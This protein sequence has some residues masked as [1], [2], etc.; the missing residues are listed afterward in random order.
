VGRHALGPACAW[1][2]KPK[3]KAKVEPSAHG[4]SFRLLERGGISGDVSP[5]IQSDS[6][7]RRSRFRAHI[8]GYRSWKARGC[9]ARCLGTGWES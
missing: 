1:A 6:R 9:V 4:L 3:M 7:R 8:I 5:V 2:A